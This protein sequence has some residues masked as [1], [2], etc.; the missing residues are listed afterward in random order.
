MNDIYSCDEGYLFMWWKIFI[1]VMNDIYSCDE[2]YL[3]T[4]WVIFIRV[5][6]NIY[7]RDGTIFSG[8]KNVSIDSY[9]LVIINCE[10]HDFRDRKGHYNP[11]RGYNIGYTKKIMLTNASGNKKRFGWSNYLFNL[12]NFRFDLPSLRSGDCFIK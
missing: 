12:S 6:N 10:P 11:T 5:M 8:F 7:S 9:E 4:W 3:F 1:H 2:R